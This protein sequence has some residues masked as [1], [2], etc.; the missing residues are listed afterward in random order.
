M[1]MATDQREYLPVLGKSCSENTCFQDFQKPRKGWKGEGSSEGEPSACQEERKKEGEE[2]AE[3]AGGE[4][5]EQGG[6][7][8]GAGGEEEE[9]EEV[10]ATVRLLLSTIGMCAFSKLDGAH[11]FC[12]FVF[13]VTIRIQ[14]CCTC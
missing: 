13:S 9:G 14:H 4:G 11:Q 1:K 5:E 2:A 10:E 7:G 12:V 3:G 6:E 8:E